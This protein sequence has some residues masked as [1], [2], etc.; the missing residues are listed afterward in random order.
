VPKRKRNR[1]LWVNTATR[2]LDSIVDLRSHGDVKASLQFINRICKAPAKL[3][4]VP[5][6]GKIV[7]ELKKFSL[8]NYREILAPPWRII[9]KVSDPNVYVMAIIDSR[10]NVEDILLDRM[11]R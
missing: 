1:V 10:R 7:P 9:Y 5:K 11:I 2:D 8:T 4:A 6:R 3:Q